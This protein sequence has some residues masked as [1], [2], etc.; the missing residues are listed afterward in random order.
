MP[1]TRYVPNHASSIG[2]VQ[3]FNPPVIRMGMETAVL[4]E[5]DVLSGSR[6]FATSSARIVNRS[7]LAA[8]GT[9][10]ATVGIGVSITLHA[11]EAPLDVPGVKKEVCKLLED[12]EDMGPTLIRL[13]WHASGTFDKKDNTGGSDGATMRF[14][15]EANH[16]ANAG[17][18]PCSRRLLVRAAVK[19]QWV[20]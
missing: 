6:T 20:W 2:M 3:R 9:S 19:P 17:V 11:A 1:A 5:T 13:A 16:G 15:E 12:N 7:W 8:A 18:P 4:A 10:I 14:K